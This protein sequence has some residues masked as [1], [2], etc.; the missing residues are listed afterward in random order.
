MQLSDVPV[1]HVQDG[2]LRAMNRHYTQADI[3]IYITEY[4]LLTA[5]GEYELLL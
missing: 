2:L 1:Q 4:V 3:T 5:A